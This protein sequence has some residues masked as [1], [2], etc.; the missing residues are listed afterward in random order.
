MA[1]G[2]VILDHWMVA[3]GQVTRSHSWGQPPMKIGVVFPGNELPSDPGSVRAYAQGV[4]ALGYL[5]IL[6][7]DHVVGADPTM[8]EGYNNLPNVAT[9]YREPFVL[10]GYIAAITSVELVTAVVVL[11]QR[12]TVL[13][14]KQAAEVD[15]LSGGRLRLGVG[16]GWNKVEYDA[17]G[18]VFATRGRRIEDQVELMRRLWTERVVTHAGPFDRVTGA[19][20]APLPVQRPIPVWFG[21][22]SDAAL[23][24]AGQLGD[25][26]FP[27][28]PPGDRLDA[29][30]A[31]VAE[32]AT[33]AGRDPSLLGMHGKIAWAP[34]AHPEARLVDHA[35]RWERA[36]ATHLS[37]NTMGVGLQGVAGHLEALAQAAEALDLANR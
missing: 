15:L 31:L 28:V 26:W 10:L 6:T 16:L 13:V 14:A 5:H 36:G 12:Q 4:E 8:H 20:L 24:R 21:A 2:H 9:P 23:R 34:G 37:V 19:G 7:Y 11:P 22:L 35:G 18:Q 17:L 29:S 3:S 30:R 32:G 33:A 25:G 27:E 1:M